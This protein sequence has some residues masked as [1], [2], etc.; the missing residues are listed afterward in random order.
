MPTNQFDKEYRPFTDDEDAI[1]ERLYHDKQ[2][3]EIAAVLGRSIDAVKRRASMLNLPEKTRTDTIK[4]TPEKCDFLRRHYN[5]PDWSGER[6]ANH[7][8]CTKLALYSQAA[9]MG[10]KNPHHRF[11]LIE[12]AFIKAKYHTENIEEIGFLLGVS[13]QAVMRRARKLGI[14]SKLKQIHYTPEMDKFMLDMAD[15]GTPLQEIANKMNKTKE[16]IKMRL[17]RIRKARRE[18]LKN[19]PA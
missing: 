19:S 1:I 17:K 11:T 16:A 4:W 14:E 5:A 9:A 18:A 8:R 2:Y 12:D 10:L 3:R 7:L 13:R 6:L 15:N